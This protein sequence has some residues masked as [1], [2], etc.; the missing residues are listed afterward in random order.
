MPATTTPVTGLPVR[1]LPDFFSQMRTFTFL[2]VIFEI[3]AVNLLL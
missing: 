3:V 1:A 2:C